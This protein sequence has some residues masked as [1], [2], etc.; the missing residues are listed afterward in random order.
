TLGNAPGARQVRPRPRPRPRPFPPTGAWIALLLAIAAPLDPAPAGPAAPRTPAAAARAAA[1]HRALG[2]L[3]PVGPPPDSSRFVLF[4]WVSTPAGPTNRARIDEMA[5]LGFNLLIPAW[6]D[7]GCPDDNLARM[8]WAAARGMRCI[9]WDSRL[10]AALQWFPTFEDTLNEIVAAYRDHP[11]LWGYYLG[12]EPP[13]SICP[14]LRRLRQSLRDRD[15]THYS[16]DSL[17]GVASF[18]STDGFAAQL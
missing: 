5:D 7:E 9:V 1:A 12:D 18:P 6:L 8:D 3:E 15:P 4:G 16:W 17:L 14:L 10:M 13:P 11:G 2:S